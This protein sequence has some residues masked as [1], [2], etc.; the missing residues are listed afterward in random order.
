MAAQEFRHDLGMLLGKGTAHH[1]HARQQARTR[2]TCQL[3]PH[4]GQTYRSRQPAFALC[5]GSGLERL[6]QHAHGRRIS[7]QRRQ[8]LGGLALKL[9]RHLA[10]QARA[11]QQVVHDVL[12]RGALARHI[13]SMAR[14][15]AKRG[16]TRVARHNVQHAQRVDVYDL[17]RALGLVV[18]HARHV[19]RH[20]GNVDIALNHLG[21]NL[22]GG[23]VDRKV[24]LVVRGTFGRLVHKLHQPNRRRALERGDVYLDRLGSG[25]V[26]GRPGS[27]ARSRP[28]PRSSAAAASQRKRQ[29]TRGERRGKPPARHF[30]IKRAH[31]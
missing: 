28:G 18:E 14:Q 13:D 29:R 19:G 22:V 21:H 4:I 16:H 26:S 17:H 7:K 2:V 25:T 20:Q 12:R 11:L 23:S 9:K 6:G 31:R 15:I 30:K 1:G 3:I 10:G 27:R 24:E 5:D 8:Y